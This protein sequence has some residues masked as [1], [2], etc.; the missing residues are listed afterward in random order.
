[1]RKKLKKK[2]SKFLSSS[3]KTNKQG[4]CIN[5]QGQIQLK[6]ASQG[7]CHQEIQVVLK[8]TINSLI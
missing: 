5:Q 4:R 1:M 6:L 3:D 2:T 8:I 7:E